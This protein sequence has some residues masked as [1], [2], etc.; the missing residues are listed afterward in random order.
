M[1]ELGIDAN[2]QAGNMRVVKYITIMVTREGMT[3]LGIEDVIVPRPVEDVDVGV[4]VLREVMM[5]GL[6]SAASVKVHN[7]HLDPCSRSQA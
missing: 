2:V 7:P 1:S 3:L 4:T 6:V 5:H